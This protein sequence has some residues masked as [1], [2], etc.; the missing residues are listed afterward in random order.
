MKKRTEETETLRAGC[1]KAEPKKFVPPQIPFPGGAGRPNFNQLQMG[2]TFTYRPSL[3][4]IDAS[5]FEL[6]WS[7]YNTPKKKH[8]HTHTPTN[9]HTQTDRTDCNTLRRS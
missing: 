1:S 4:R 3:V 6:S 2:I 9:T 8:T 5:N 7:R